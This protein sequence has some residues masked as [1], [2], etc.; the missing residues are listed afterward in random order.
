MFVAR[1]E[2][3]AQHLPRSLNRTHCNSKNML[4]YENLKGELYPPARGFSHLISLNVTRDPRQLNCHSICS[5]VGISLQD[6]FLFRQRFLLSFN[7][8]GLLFGVFVYPNSYPTPNISTEYIGCSSMCC[9]WEDALH[10][11]DSNLRA[12]AQEKAAFSSLSATGC[13]LTDI[14]CICKDQSLV[15]S[16]LP[17]LQNQCS[18]A[19]LQSMSQSQN[20]RLI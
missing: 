2:Q 12:S 13:Q 11:F 19:D 9:T 6:L 10:C 7:D 5:L 1:V 17:V 14:E 4:L 8:H 20:V 18:P 3:T 15:T 16:L